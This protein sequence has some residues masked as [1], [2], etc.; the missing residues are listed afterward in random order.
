MSLQLKNCSIF[1]VK[2]EAYANTVN[3]VGVMGAGIAA[4]FKKRY[5]EMF[6]E[7]Q[8]ECLMHSINPGDCWV[9]KDKDAY[10]LNLA[11]KRD[12]REWATKEWIEQ[13]FKSFKLEVLEHKIKSVALPVIGG[14]NARR[15]P[16]GQISGF[17][18]PPNKDELK[19]WLEKELTKFADN[20]DLEIYLCTPDETPIVTQSDRIKTMAKQFFNLK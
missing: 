13:S 3:V 4:E 17:T 18:P 14:K 7:Y 5:P 12:W 1:D 10:L 2:V 15:G 8:T 11:V 19:Q 20:F 6:K 9:Y 16:W